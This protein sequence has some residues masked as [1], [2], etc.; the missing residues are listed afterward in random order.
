MVGSSDDVEE[1]DTD[2]D[3]VVSDWCD[4]GGEDGGGGGRAGV[5]NGPASS[6]GFG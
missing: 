5:R 1:C 3:A 4:G 2:D 6:D